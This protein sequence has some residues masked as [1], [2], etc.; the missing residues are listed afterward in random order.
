[1]SIRYDGAARRITLEQSLEFARIHE[2]VY[3]E[4]GYELVAIPAA[5][6]AARASM[7]EDHITRTR[8]VARDHDHG[9]FSAPPAHKRP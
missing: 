9:R 1:M 8:P 5:A 2:E 3:S 7:I 6:A 4:H